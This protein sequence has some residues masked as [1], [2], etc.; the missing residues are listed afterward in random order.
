MSYHCPRLLA[1]NRYEVD[2]SNEVLNIDLEVEKKSAS[3]APGVRASVLNPAE[4]AIFFF[5]F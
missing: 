4:S 3:A 2:L 1:P 5:D